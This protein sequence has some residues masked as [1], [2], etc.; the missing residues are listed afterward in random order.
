MRRDEFLCDD[1]DFIVSMLH[2][3]PFATLIIPDI[4]FAYALPLS[5]CF[6]KN[7]ADKGAVYFHGAKS[8][9]K[10]E[11]LQK[12]HKVSLS[13]AKPYSYIPSSFLEGKMI[14]TQFFFSVFIEGSFKQV[15]DLAF[16]RDILSKLVQKYEPENAEFS[17]QKGQFK[18]S[19]NGVFV[20]LVKV[21][22]LSAKAKFGQNL[23]ENAFETIINDLKRRHTA[24]DKDT[25]DLM[26]Y[27]RQK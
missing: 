10:F 18:G 27:F 24:Q 5:F 23:N 16:K 8:G 4:P 11:L 26:H 2:Q 15:Q 19:E 21:Q 14:P 6:D 9:R 3:I 20:G 1:M 25:V 7:Y 17:M 12:E 22:N 13:V